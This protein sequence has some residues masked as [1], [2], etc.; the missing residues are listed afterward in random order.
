MGKLEYEYAGALKDALILRRNNTIGPSEDEQLGLIAESITSWALH[1]SVKRGKLW[2]EHLSD[3][4]FVAECV[5]T[6]I[7]YYDKVCLDRAPKEILL[8][9]KKVAQSKARDMVNSMNTM[10]R[11]HEEVDLEGATLESDLYG[12]RIWVEGHAMDY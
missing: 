7:S 1:D 9:L 2:H 12:N 4:D 5:C 11:Q 6:V 10:K 8:Y 3:V